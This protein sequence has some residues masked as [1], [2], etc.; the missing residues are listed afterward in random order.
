MRDP[1]SKQGDA[2]EKEREMSQDGSV[3]MI[4]LGLWLVLLVVAFFRA[5]STAWVVVTIAIVGGFVGAGLG[6]LRDRDIAL[7]RFGYQWAVVVVLF[8]VA[9]L[10][11]VPALGFSASAKGTTLGRGGSFG[12]RRQ[13]LGTWVPVGLVIGVLFLIT[14]FMTEGPAFLRPVSYLMGNGDAEDNAKWLASAAKFASGAPVEQAVPM[15]GPLELLMTVVGTFMGAVSQIALGGYNE[16]AI[17][18]NMVVLGEFLMVGV[19]LFALAPLVESR[20]GGARVPL[21]LLW[22]SSLV[23]ASVALVLVGFGHLTL[24]FTILVAGLWSATFLSGLGMRRARLLSSL[25]VAT[26]MTVWFP[27][28]GVAAV[29]L[30]GW[31]AVLIAR[32][33]RFGWRASDPVGV[34]LVV[35]VLV[36]LAQ[37]VISSVTYSL[38]IGAS[39]A[40]AFG[41]AVS[42]ISSTVM[43]VGWGI[44]D[45]SVF[46]AQGGTEQVGPIFGVITAVS[47]LAA[48]VFLQGRA[49][50][51]STSLVRRFVPIGLLALS[52]LGIY[53]LD[54]WVT[55]DGP[56]YGSLKFAFMLA[57]VALVTTLPLALMLI[58]PEAGSRMSQARWI[59]LG[60]IVFLLTIDSLLP[61]AVAQARPQEWSPP[62]PFNNTSGS[63]WYPAEVNGEA[64][65]PISSAPVACMYLPE[66]SRVPTAIVPSGL[67]DAQR[68][69]SCSR[70]LAGLSGVDAEAQPLVD[71]L[72]REWL[73]NTPAWADVYD[74]LLSLPDSVL[75]KP[76]ILLDDGSNVIGLE[77]LRALLA[78]YPKE[79]AIG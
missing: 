36:L 42:G 45:S 76:V 38:G 4:F 63:Y 43:R 5:R 73:T 57:V 32:G 61:R 41:G 1:W 54:F 14:T 12:W 64:V 55:G 13:I 26:T 15:G 24:Q 60:I 68:V 29:I 46:S 47:V 44:N 27:M 34:G 23:L 71:W 49:G 11:W 2:H 39:T 74:G 30:I 21:P 22:L 69:Y 59:G 9:L 65:Q 66:G 28:S 50:P 8:I 77:S 72:R 70:L 6:F 79:L 75:D 56:N 48:A 17:A 3:D 16:V 37:P 67:S 78:R 51:V 7:D 40:S 35:A 58:T 53:I 62:I 10:A 52:A 25:A 19:V 20:F 33:F 18:A 31:L